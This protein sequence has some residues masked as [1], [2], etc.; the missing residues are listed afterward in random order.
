MILPRLRIRASLLILALVS[1]ACASPGRYVWVDD[2]ADT[3]RDA[4][5]PLLIAVGDV[6]Q[7]KVFNQEQL[8][9][10]TRVREDGKISIPLVNDVTAAGLTPVALAGELQERLKD[11]VKS[12]LVTVSIEETRPPTV[13]VTGEVTKPGVYPLE[14][15]GS[16]LAALANAG[17]LT[18]FASTNR[19]FVLRQKPVE[20]RI[21]FTYDAL[22]HMAGKAASFRLRPGDVI[23]VE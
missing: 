14:P 20:T 1:L 9:T 12:P 8:S 13:Y 22:T 7:V 11:Y 3:D 16:V 19:I 4:R 2:Y 21:R 17:G 10:K 18:Q 5:T 6:L 15:P 23:V